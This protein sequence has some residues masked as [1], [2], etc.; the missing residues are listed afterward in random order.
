[1]VLVLYEENRGMEGTMAIIPFIFSSN[2]VEKERNTVFDLDS[3]FDHYHNDAVLVRNLDSK[4]FITGYRASNCSYDLRI[5]RYYVDH[6]KE[7]QIDLSED[8]PNIKLRPGGAVIIETEE[9]VEFPPSRF[10]Q[11]LPKVTLLKKGISNT[12]SKIDPG[13]KGNLLITV[14]NL[15]RQTVILKMGEP[16]C[17]MIVQDVNPPAIPYTKEPIKPIGKIRK[18]IIQKAINIIAK[19]GPLVVAIGTLA[20]LILTIVNIIKLSTSK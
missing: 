14:F 18:R 12:T 16:F 1:M 20:T 10:G 17:S 11:I 4:Q 9:Y 2:D 8:D 3:D 6:R 15:G 13:Y 19:N 5:G 7:G